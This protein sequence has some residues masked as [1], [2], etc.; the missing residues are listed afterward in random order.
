MAWSDYQVIRCEAYSA[1]VALS[2]RKSPIKSPRLL[3]IAQY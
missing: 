2:R 1:K 3:L